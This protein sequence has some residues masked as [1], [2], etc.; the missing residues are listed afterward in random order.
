[1]A[2]ME[3]KACIYCGKTYTNVRSSKMVYSDVGQYSV[4]TVNG[5]QEGSQQ[6]ME[7]AHWCGKCEKKMDVDLIRENLK[8]L[9]KKCKQ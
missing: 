7:S 2:Y 6:A 9:V 8:E 1:M 5:H 3:H 4:S